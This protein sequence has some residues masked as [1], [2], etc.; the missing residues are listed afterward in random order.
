MQ[1][2]ATF[3]QGLDRKTN[4]YLDYEEEN[5]EILGKKKNLYYKTSIGRHRVSTTNCL[6]T[7]KKKKEA[8]KGL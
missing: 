4:F 2:W 1:N 5:K 7:K 3:H 6:N 8:C